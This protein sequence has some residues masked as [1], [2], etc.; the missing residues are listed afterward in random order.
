MTDKC[1][2]VTD[3]I[4]V[5]VCDGSLK[6]VSMEINVSGEK[7]SVP[8]RVCRVCGNVSVDAQAIWGNRKIF[9]EP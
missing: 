7:F 5:T 1:K 2:L 6:R 4:L 3:V 9:Q 8:T